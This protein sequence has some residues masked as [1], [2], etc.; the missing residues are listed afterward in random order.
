MKRILTL[1]ALAALLCLSACDGD[2]LAETFGDN[3]TVAGRY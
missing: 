2:P 1:S 3:T